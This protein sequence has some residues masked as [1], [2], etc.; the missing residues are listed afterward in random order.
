[1]INVNEKMNLPVV[2]IYSEFPLT[3]FGGGERLIIMIYESLKKNGFEVKIIENN[4]MIAESRIGKEDILERVGSDLLFISFRRYGLPR[5]L[6]QDFPDLMELNSFPNSICLIFVRRLP[7]K[8]ILSEI[9]KFSGIKLVFCLHGIALEKLRL[10]DPRIMIHQFIIRLQ[11]STF[12]RFVA[13][14]VYAQCLTPRVGNYLQYRGGRQN[15]VF[16]IENE[17]QSEITDIISNDSLFQVIFIGRMQKLT[18][19]IKFLKKVILKVKKIEP[20][21]EFVV[22]GNGPDIYV[23]DDLKNH[24]K[25]LTNADDM[26]KEET[27]L[28][29]NL[30]IIT[31][32][33]EPFPRVAL[34]FLTSGIPVVTTPA[35]GPSYIIG[36]DKIFGNVSS[37]NVTDFSK[38]IIFYYEL[39]KSDKNAYFELR[40]NIA[41]KA[42]STFNEKNML[43]SYLK[44]IVDIDSKWRSK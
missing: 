29:S 12:A 28:H 31:S 24:C 27:V 11:L 6:Y 2:K 26:I 21:I 9:S 15:N 33:L 7:P 42:R 1:M 41:N 13:G 8:S 18:K 16:V 3:Y 30:A 44:M 35:F 34:E 5:F 39:W 40:K 37:F 32:G 19:G 43:D 22:I 36:K 38:D 14:N 17:F 23:L 4:R 20:S 10:A 25:L